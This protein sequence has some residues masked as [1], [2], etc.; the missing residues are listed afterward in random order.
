MGK[1]LIVAIVM[2]ET[3]SR[4]FSLNC[5]LR[6]KSTS[7]TKK[8]PVAVAYGIQRNMLTRKRLVKLKFFLQAQRLY[9]L[10]GSTDLDTC[11]A[12]GKHND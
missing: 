12:L 11:P 8:E 7:P 10:K 5:I 3:V 2:D 9:Q 1:R 6:S 4:L